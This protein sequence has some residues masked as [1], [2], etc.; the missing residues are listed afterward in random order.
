[1]S[2]FV[3]FYRHFSPRLSRL[4]LAENTQI[5]VAIFLTGARQIAGRNAWCRLAAPALHKRHAPRSFER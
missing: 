2:H 3:R 4:V 1:M 5:R